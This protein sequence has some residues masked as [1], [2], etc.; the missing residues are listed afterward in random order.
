[1]PETP[2]LVILNVDD[3][4]AGLYVKSRILRQE[5]FVVIEAAT[6]NE[7][8]RLVAAEQ[9]VLVLLDVKLPDI[10]GLEVCR[11]IKTDPATA[12][13]LVLQISAALGEPQDRV[14]G[15]ESGADGYLVDPITPAELIAD[16]KALVRLW[17]R[18]EEN[19]QLL[20]RLQQEITERK[21]VEEALRESEARLRA[22]VNAV[23][24]ILL[25]LDEDGR[26]AE[27]LTAQSPLLYTEPA[28]LKGKLMSEVLPAELAQRL[29]N[30]IRQTLHTRQ[31]QSVEYELQIRKA[32]KRYF[33]ARI[34]FL[35]VPMLDKPA[36][37][38]LA[39]DIT[40]RRLTED[41]LQQAQKMEAIGHLTGGVAHDFN[42]LLAIILG[43]LELLAEVP[44]R[45]ELQD[46]VQRSLGAAERGVTL[47]RRLLAFARRQSLQAQ[48]VGLNQLVVGITD[49]L[50]RTL[51]E[52]I[53]IETALAADL[54][55]TMIDPSQFETA[56]LNL[57]LNARDAMPNG[58]RLTIETANV[59][60]GENY[61]AVHQ[62]VKP[63]RYVLLAI[64][65]TGI[66]MPSDVLER[67]FEP[68]FTTKEVGKGSGLG[69][70]MVYW[71]GQAVGRVY[72]VVQ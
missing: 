34:A 40:Q 14:R 24:D 5:G 12:A 47:V 52:T 32:G 61:A 18:E 46:L 20:A 9:P 19:R 8:L 25:V 28:A 2:Q 64:S 42:N 68:F 53:Q 15:L 22:I 49:L 70:S 54:A 21:A 57:A 17:R 62:S 31:T 23:P 60:L 16:V 50:R 51:G 44:D 41:N 45:P 36:V 35:E 3:N 1:M 56:L 37:I 43:N 11:R 69:L 58:G 55:P 29:L 4:A 13:T 48:P 6:G 10:N 63:G 30:S 66:G 38:L 39:H 33:E 67:A 27:I 72:P 59:W 26:Y 71:S 65:D 7:A